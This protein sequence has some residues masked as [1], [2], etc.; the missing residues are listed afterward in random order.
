MMRIALATAA[1]VV[2]AAPASAQMD[3]SI[4]IVIDSAAYI[5]QPTISGDQYSYNV[6]VAAEVD[7]GSGTGAT[8]LVLYYGGWWETIY[9]WARIVPTSGRLSEPGLWR[10][11]GTPLYLFAVWDEDGTGTNR[12][13]VYWT[14]NPPDTTATFHVVDST[15]NDDAGLAVARRFYGDT[16]LSL[17]WVRDQRNLIYSVPD[18]SGGWKSIMVFDAAYSCT[19][20]GL[21]L[22][23][24]AFYPYEPRSVLLFEHRNFVSP[25]VQV[26]VVMMDPTDTTVIT[27]AQ[28]FGWNTYNPTF[29]EEYFIEW[30]IYHIMDD[31]PGD[32]DVWVTRST[33]QGITWDSTYAIDTTD[34]EQRA[35]TATSA[36]CGGSFPNPQFHFIGGT[37]PDTMFDVIGGWPGVWADTVSDATFD[38]PFHLAVDAPDCWYA[39]WVGTVGP[40]Q[41]LFY[42]MHAITDV[43]GSAVLPVKPSLAVAPNPFNPTTTFSFDL[44]EA[45]EVR[46]DV[47]DVL[48]RRVATLVDAS[49]PAGSH[50][51]VWDASGFPSGMYFGRLITERSTIS[52]KVV[53]LR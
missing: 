25:N 1:V 22:S 9:E 39:V 3:W 27:P 48:G 53:L 19:L 15:A 26:G 23:S 21:E 31:P 28:L 45:S 43:P 13:I 4:D 40:Q 37:P 16:C 5:G 52:S 2:L 50:Y 44:P 17:A 35:I 49:L 24:G 38:A 20:S 34:C 47:Y 14:F 10:S 41:Y 18:G 7:D 33:D 46:L 8:N 6:F 12:D 11:S 36:I 32:P 51:T 30:D 29:S 42:D